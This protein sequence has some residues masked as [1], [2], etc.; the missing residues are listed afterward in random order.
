MPLKIEQG[1]RYRGDDWW[2]WWVWLDGATEELDQVDK[3][4]YTLHHT[5]PNPVRTVSSR[6]DKFLLR[7]SGWGVFRIHAAVHRKDGSVLKLSH[8]LVL[9]YPDGTVTT[10]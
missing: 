9:E 3:V 5:F 2:Q 6:A 1:F 7:T 4:V 8:D 10:A